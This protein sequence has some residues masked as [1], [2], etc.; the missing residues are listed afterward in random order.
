[1]DGREIELK[2][3]LAPADMERVRL[4]PCFDAH[5][6]EA[7]TERRLN[8]T[9]F[10]TPDFAL[11][12]AGISLRVRHV[13]SRYI[14]TVKTAGTSTSGLFQRDEWETPV[15]SAVPETEPLLATGLAIFTDADLVG[16]LAPVYSTDV[17]RT[18]Y[19]LTG[20][21]PESGSA[22][23][24]EAALDL[25]EVAA[26]AAR[27]GICEIEFELVKGAPDILFSVAR[28]VL[29]AVPAR[30]LTATKSERGFLLATGRGIVPVKAKAPPLDHDLSVATAFQTIGRSCLDHLLTNERCLLAT[31]HGEAIHQMR[32]ALRRLRSAI[33][34]FRPVLDT[35]RLTEIKADLRWL[36]A[37][38]GPARD[39]D[40]FLAEI[41]DP[42]VA[43]HPGISGLNALRAHWL[44][45]R[46]ARLATAIE[47]VRSR[48]FAAMALQLGEWVESGDWLRPANERA[49]RKLDAPIPAFAVG[50]LGKATRRLLRTAG[51][52]LGRLP[53]EQLHAVRIN[54]K[55]VR[56]A[57]EFFAS[58][59]PRKHMKVF[60][61]ELSELQDVLGKLNDIN[62]AGPKLAGRHAQG[63]RSKAAGMVSGWHEARRAPL[64][65]EAQKAWKRW[66][67][68]PLP[69]HDA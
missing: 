57:G 41:I 27:E 19:R 46:D 60:L 68:Y 48:R 28:Q 54:G 63:G 21:E 22:W 37:H 11:A 1:M 43:A 40:V 15:A 66:R 64:L 39:A 16:R 25:G 55:Q 10:D 69:W 30:P 50:R 26:G 5:A 44:A 31:G 18:L 45:D 56:Y 20:G 61:A 38:L 52:D 7:P 32:V 67:N 17:H 42:V 9:Y 62:V 47:A 12:D 49:R 33:K 4:R 36:L 35:P 8:S 3:G 13:G 59:V 6:K 65:A 51:D 34:V 29:D 24:I 14:Q 2:L 23:E 58:L 53:P